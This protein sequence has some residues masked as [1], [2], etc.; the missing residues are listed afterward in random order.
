V[1]LTGGTG[2]VATA[3]VLQASLQAASLNSP[4][5]K[6]D[7]A[8]EGASKTAGLW[9][10][11]QRQQGA[12][13]FGVLTAH[14]DKA[15]L[16]PSVLEGCTQLAMAAP[17]AESPLQP[18]RVG[19]LDCLV[20]GWSAEHAQR[21]HLVVGA[22]TASAA[23]DRAA[24]TSTVQA[25]GLHYT[26]PST[27]GALAAAVEESAADL[28]QH[29]L[30]YTTSW[31][32]AAPSTGGAPSMCSRPSTFALR[33]AAAQQLVELGASLPPLSTCG[34][35]MQLL[36]VAASARCKHLSLTAADTSSAAPLTGNRRDNFLASAAPA[37]L[38]C[39]LSEQHDMKGTVH[40]A[41]AH[42]AV[43]DLMDRRACHDA[44]G[45][46]L[47]GG[48][49]HSPRLLP[50][51]SPLDGSGAP[52][53]RRCLISGG[54]GALGTLTAGWLARSCGA[55]C[56]LLGRSGRLPQPQHAL[57]LGSAPVILTA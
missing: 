4:A 8:A 31:Q 6:P 51:I 45:E 25:G 42:A 13:A 56:V 52:T 36:Q 24:A 48:A 29:D 43:A 15:N 32:A 38:R 22:A 47:S 28:A 39:V 7:K 41:D 11:W 50:G 33:R 27:A 49:L 19:A 18:C 1:A 14:G 16:L 34:T 17:A 9:K 44:Y 3:P 2:A 26:L 37:M 54:T 46:L 10:M 21:A 23:L 35:T 5:A 40:L 20:A 55:A 53:L 12:A 30:L 57:L